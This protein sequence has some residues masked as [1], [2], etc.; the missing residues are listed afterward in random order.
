MTL[1]KNISTMVHGCTDSVVLLSHVNTDLEQNKVDHI[2]Y[3]LY[4]QYHALRK[5]V[6]A[7]SEFLFWR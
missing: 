2:A 3:C 7:D 6:L 1:S 4:N 5:N